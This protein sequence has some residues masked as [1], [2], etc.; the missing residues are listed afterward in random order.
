MSQT[1]SP[2]PELSS[3]CLLSGG[4][5]LVEADLDEGLRL[6]VAGPIRVIADDDP[7]EALAAPLVDLVCVLLVLGALD[8]ADDLAD[9]A[10]VSRALHD[11][12]AH[13][14][15]AKLVGLRRTVAATVVRRVHGEDVAA[16]VTDWHSSLPGV[17]DV[18]VAA[19]GEAVV[20]ASPDWDDRCSQVNSLDDQPTAVG[21]LDG[22]PEESRRG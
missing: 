13:L 4:Y 22:A 17:G 9:G 16:V 19:Q 8:L 21:Q 11:A 10:G 12:I 20:L 18:D 15:F 7:G 14:G 2:N 1:Y 5:D 6:V 3:A